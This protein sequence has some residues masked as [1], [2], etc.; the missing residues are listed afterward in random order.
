M[1]SSK[2]HL[3]VLSVPN[4]GGSNANE[5]LAEKVTMQVQFTILNYRRALAMMH[6]TISHVS[7]ETQI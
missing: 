5:A 7:T 4:K 1:I 3:D 2:A 6:A